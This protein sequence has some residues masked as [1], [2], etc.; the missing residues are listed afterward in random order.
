MKRRKDCKRIRRIVALIYRKKTID[1]LKYIEGMHL[2]VEI[3]RALI[4]LT[5]SH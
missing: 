3:I 5:K 4:D 2:T 1:M